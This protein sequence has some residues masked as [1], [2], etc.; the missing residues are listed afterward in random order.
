MALILLS[1]MPINV[2]DDALLAHPFS[3]FCLQNGQTKWLLRLCV[4][5]M[6]IKI[7]L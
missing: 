7:K 1:N 3:P 2:I 5:T 6:V 4:N